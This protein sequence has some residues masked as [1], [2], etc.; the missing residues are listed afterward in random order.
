MKLHPNQPIICSLWLALM[1]F[2][3]GLHYPTNDDRIPPI[4]RVLC[5]WR[6]V[7]IDIHDKL[8]TRIF[9]LLLLSMTK[10][11]CNAVWHGNWE[12]YT[13]L[14]FSFEICLKQPLHMTRLCFLQRQ[15]CVTLNVNEAMAALHESQGRWL[16]L[17]VVCGSVF[18]SS[19]NPNEPQFIV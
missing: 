1:P 6:S 7:K 5:M 14:I 13:P 16:I 15:S 17:L 9:Y 11:L 3:Y 18:M 2:G 19:Q 8:K 4:D 12:M 10:A